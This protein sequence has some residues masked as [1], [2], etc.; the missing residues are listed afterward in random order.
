MKIFLIVMV[1][2]M[3]LIFAIFVYYK[4]LIKYRLYRDCEYLCQNLKN[5]IAFNKKEISELLKLSSEN[6][7][8]LSKNSG[9]RVHSS[10]QV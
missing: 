7:S 9:Q 5:N 1:F 6:L 2:L 3:F 8:N 10:L 4:Y